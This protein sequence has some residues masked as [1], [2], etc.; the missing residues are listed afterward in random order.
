MKPICNT[1]LLS[2][3]FNFKLRRYIKESLAA[4]LKAQGGRGDFPPVVGQCRLTPG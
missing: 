1:L 4:E 2:F 3:A